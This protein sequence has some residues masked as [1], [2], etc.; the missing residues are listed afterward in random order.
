MQ[1]SIDSDRGDIR[2]A[3]VV[4]ASDCALSEDWHIPFREILGHHETGGLAVYL[5]E[6][7][8]GAEVP[9]HSHGL[10]DEFLMDE[11]Y[12]IES[13]TATVTL[14]DEAYDVE[15]G[16]LVWIPRGARHSVKAGPDGLRVW[17][18]VAWLDVI[19]PGRPGAK[20]SY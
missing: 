10:E 17:A 4:R 1:S 6:Y 20:T 11:I 18:L 3:A 5:L 12:I 16:D 9:R 19:H 7:G 15:P 14:E 2:G 13:G 8:D